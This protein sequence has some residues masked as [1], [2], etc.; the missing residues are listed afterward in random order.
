MVPE[1]KASRHA[2]PSSG[3]P[4][5]VVA[6]HRTIARRAASDSLADAIDVLGRAGATERLPF[7]LGPDGSYDSHLNR[8]FRELPEWGVKSENGID[9]YCSDIALIC[10]FLHEARGGKSI[11]QVDGADLRAYKQ[12]RLFAANP[13][14]RIKESTW[15]RAMAAL[16]KWVRWSLYERLLT[17]EPFRYVDKTVMTSQGVKQVRV[18]AEAEVDWHRAPITFLPYEDYLLW[19]DV[20]LLGRLPDGGRDPG[21]RG[22]NGQRNALFAD[23]VVCTGMRLGEA[24]SLLVPELPPLAPERGDLHLS[25]AVVKRHRSRTVFMRRQVLRE[26]HHYLGIERDELVQRCRVAGAYDICGDHLTV[27]RASRQA[28]VVDGARRSWAYSA[29]DA[30]QRR[31]LM[32]VD[33]QGRSAGP[34][35]L[36]LGEDG[37]PLRSSTWQSAF[38]RANERCARFGIDFEVHPHTLRH[39]FAVHMLGLLL[40]QTIRAMGMQEDRHFTLAQIKRMLIGNPMRKLQLLL[41]HARE[42]TVYAYLDVLDE[43]QE[44]VLSA[45]AEWDD[46]AAVLDRLQV[47]TAEVAR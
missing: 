3:E 14:D 20:G 42:E 37:Q 29:I 46:Q 9:G 23:L 34:L 7:V 21:W 6:S 31:R 35:W 36:W 17:K 2:D 45:L 10:R 25:A 47:P 26:L 15:S 44:I 38:R 12:A 16:D 43:A 32:S 39:T 4:Q 13:D 41:G 28:L 1:F 24:S 30:D 27:R 22:R 5:A 18:I 40:R 33:S 19:R 11:W 8:F